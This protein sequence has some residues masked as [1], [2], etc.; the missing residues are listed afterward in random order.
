M[1]LIFKH[2]K[3]RQYIPNYQQHKQPNMNNNNDNN[4]NDNDNDEKIKEGEEILLPEQIEQIKGRD[5]AYDIRGLFSFLRKVEIENKEIHYHWQIE[6]KN[7]PFY[8]LEGPIDDVTI[9][10]KKTYSSFGKV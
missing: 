9:K 1:I 6:F 7:Y 2:L 10:H 4:N 3:I 8:G 5:L